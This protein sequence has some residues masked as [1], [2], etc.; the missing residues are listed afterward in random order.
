[1]EILEKS[2][3]LANVTGM[4]STNE[5]LEEI[6]TADLQYLLLPALLGSLSLKLT[7]GD[8]KE[9]IDVAEIYFKDFLQ[10]CN[11][12]GL[13]DYVFK[14]KQPQMQVQS[15]TEQQKLTDMVNTR[16]NKI[17]RFRE[18][19]E[20]EAQLAD[21]KKNME[22]ENVDEEIKRKYFITMVKL[23]IHQA[24]LELDSIEMEKPILAHMQKLKD[25]E[26]MFYFIHVTFS[27]TTFILKNVNMFFHSFNNFYPCSTGSSS[28]GL[29]KHPNPP[30]PKPLKPIILTKDEVQKAVFG[31]GYPAL[32]TMTVKEFYDKRV[33]EGIFPDPSKVKQN[34]PMSLQ[35][36][37]L[38][39]QELTNEKEDI[40]IENKIESDDPENLQ[41]MRDKD[42]FKDDHRR[43]WGNRM[44]RS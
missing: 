8:R 25:E 5:S 23:Y 38:A 22:N 30:K 12:Y 36:A 27:F 14:D 43:G 21:L 33:E 29:K 35:Q 41:R 4:F 39:G 20:L 24:I 3:K 40:D 7:S 1:M 31:A 42:E 2:T 15:K 34:Q 17:L 6:A 44:N 10:R 9:I 19:K 32:P 16:Q 37:A 26:G 28:S 11:D 13:S 18:Q